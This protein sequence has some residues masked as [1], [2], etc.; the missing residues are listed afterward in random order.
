MYQPTTKRGKGVIDKTRNIARKIVCPKGTTPLF[1]GERHYPCMAFMGPGTKIQE[2]LARGDKPLN[3][4][5]KFAME[6]DIDYYNIGQMIKNGNNDKETIDRLVREADQ[7]FINGIKANT[8]K[9]LFNKLSS[10]VGASLI[11]GKTLLED[12]KIWDKQKFVGD[13]LK[14][15]KPAKKTKKQV[16]RPKK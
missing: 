13:G 15:K 7:R 16:G 4:A 1:P 2:R 14:K 10:F 6:H 9:G 12:A 5:D 3:I 11:K 8:D